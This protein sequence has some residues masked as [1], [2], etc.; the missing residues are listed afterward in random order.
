MEGSRSVTAKFSFFCFASRF[1]PS[2][3]DSSLPVLLDPKARDAAVL[4]HRGV[5][6]RT[7]A[8]AYVDK[9]DSALRVPSLLIADESV[10][11]LAR[12]ASSS[13]AS[14]RCRAACSAMDAAEEVREGARKHLT[15]GA[16]H[17]DAF[18]ERQK[19]T[20]PSE[21]RRL[22]FFF[23][24]K[25]K[26]NLDRPFLFFSFD[27]ESRR[28][29]S[30]PPLAPPRRVSNY[31]LFRSLHVSFFQDRP[32]FGKRSETKDRKM[33]K[34]GTP[35]RFFASS[36]FLSQSFAEKKRKT[37]FSFCSS[38]SL[39]LSIHSCSSYALMRTLPIQEKRKRRKGKRKEM[40]Y[41]IDGCF[42][43]RSKIRES[44]FFFS[45]LKKTENRLSP[46]HLRQNGLVSCRPASSS[47][48][49]P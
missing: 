33:A 12:L 49:S 8:R 36:R 30:L 18:R 35:A 2:S 17:F 32:E 38:L 16:G 34:A 44:F 19:Q 15:H 45:S 14:A 37:R 40:R 39:S 23:F 43:F 3:S 11:A 1:V 27:D 22:C 9:Q 7:V 13:F 31:W 28:R 42:S 6:E 47:V 5:A 20:S 25:K 4:G 46:P 21:S 24:L 10:V 29:R 48:E 26:K 41:N